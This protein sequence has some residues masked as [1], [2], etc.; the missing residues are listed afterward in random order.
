MD[1][2][3]SIRDG[4]LA[5]IRALMAKTVDNG[6]TEAEAAAAAA[7]VDRLLAAYELTLDEVNVRELVVVQRRVAARHHHVAEA[8]YAIGQFTDCR[9]W[10]SGNDVIFLGFAVDTEIAEYLTLVFKRAIDSGTNA[11]TLFNHAYDAAGSVQRKEMLRCFAIGMADRLAQRLLTLK[12]KRD[13]TAR[14]STGRDLVMLKKPIVD[15]AFDA[16]G[17]LLRGGKQRREIGDPAAYAA[18]Q[19]SAEHVA[20]NQ[21]IAARA[22]SSSMIR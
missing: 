2:Q 7:A 4:Q 8:V 14:E 17:L 3:R 15:A 21:G 16:L 22:R 12:S 6:C 20:I 1:N 13:F 9:T 10:F 18:G 19:K 5:R 11:H